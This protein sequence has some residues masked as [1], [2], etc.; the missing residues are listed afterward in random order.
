MHSVAG[1]VRSV[2]GAPGIA[3]DFAARAPLLVRKQLGIAAVC[4]GVAAVYGS[5]AAVLGGVAAVCGGAAL[6]FMEAGRRPPQSQCRTWP[7]RLVRGAGAR[8]QYGARDRG[9]AGVA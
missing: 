7:E 5:V 4:G 9:Q 6:P 8:Y 3:F 2:P 1:P